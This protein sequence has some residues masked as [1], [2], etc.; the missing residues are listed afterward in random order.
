MNGMCDHLF[1]V[2][3]D[4]S[5]NFAC[6]NMKSSLETSLNTSESSVQH[7]KERLKNPFAPTIELAANHEHCQRK[8]PMWMQP[9][10]HNYI[11]LLFNASP[12]C[13]VLLQ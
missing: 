9:F 5:S 3:A 1:F 6:M 4:D 10:G 7:D 2:C 11:G 8:K 13:R 12:D